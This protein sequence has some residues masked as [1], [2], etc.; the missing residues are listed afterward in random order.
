MIRCVVLL[1]SLL[2]LCGCMDLF[3]PSGCTQTVFIT[4]SIKV[5]QGTDTTAHVDT[6]ARFK[7]CAQ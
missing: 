4:D 7:L 5:F 3:R 6:L 1:V 2:G